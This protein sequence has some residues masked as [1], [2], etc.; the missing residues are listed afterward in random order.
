MIISLR[1]IAGMRLEIHPDPAIVHVGDKV[2]WQLSLL[3]AD[4][5][6]PGSRRDPFSFGPLKWT[7]YFRNKQPFGPNGY[8]ELSTPAAPGSPVG[9]RF[10]TA[11]TPGD[12][13]YGVRLVDARGEEISDDDPFLIVLR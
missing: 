13:K 4:R 11:E 9:M 10:G 12:Y 3:P 6:I 2:Q 8:T 5:D 7:V 1:S